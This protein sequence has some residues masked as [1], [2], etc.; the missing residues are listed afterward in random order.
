M[1]TQADRWRHAIGF[2]LT[3]LILVVLGLRRSRDDEIDLLSA[4]RECQ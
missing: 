1:R 4:T 2:E 3:G